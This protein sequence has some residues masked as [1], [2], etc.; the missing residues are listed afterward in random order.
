MDFFRYLHHPYALTEHTHVIIDRIF[1]PSPPEVWE[2]RPIVSAILSPQKKLYPWLVTLKKLNEENIRQ[3]S[4]LINNTTRQ[5][6]IMAISSQYTDEALTLRLADALIFQHI[7]SGERYLL[8]YYD[9]LVYLQLLRILTSMQ[10]QNLNRMAGID[11]CTWFDNSG[12]VTVDCRKLELSG[13][14]GVNQETIRRLQ[15]VGL[16]NQVIQQYGTSESI[17]S[18]I[19]ISN[20]IEKYIDIAQKRFGLTHQDDIKIFAVCGLEL[21]PFFWQSSRV[22]K[23]L[24]ETASNPGAFS[25]E[26]ALLDDSVRTLIISD[27]QFK[28]KEK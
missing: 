5:P 4:S 17:K 13:W 24:S 15:N 1:Y 25:D 14:G 8:R 16:I 22:I 21:H 10:L 26:I 19:I 27:C 23:I 2:A 3:L 11:Y 12:G 7:N 9:S 28:Y 18:K 20:E 6:F